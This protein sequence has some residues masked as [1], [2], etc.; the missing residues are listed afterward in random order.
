MSAPEWYVP[1]PLSPLGVYDSDTIRDIQRTLSVP[2][3]GVMDE[4]T[5]SHI[6]GLQYAMGIPGTGR[7]DE[8]TAIRIQG[9]RERYAVRIEEAEPVSAQSEA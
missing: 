3:T 9:L 8:A 2:E 5:I 6:K 7:I 4:G 1:Q